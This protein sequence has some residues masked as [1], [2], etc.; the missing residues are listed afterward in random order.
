MSTAATSDPQGYI[1][2]DDRHRCPHNVHKGLGCSVCDPAATQERL[3]LR[4]SA[5]TPKEPPYVRF[6][7]MG[8]GWLVCRKVT[9]D[10]YPQTVTLAGPFTSREGA[11]ERARTIAQSESGEYP[12]MTVN[13]GPDGRYCVQFRRSPGGTLLGR[14]LPSSDGRGRG[15]PTSWEERL[16][17]AD[18]DDHRRII[19]AFLEILGQY[20]L[21]ATT[22]DT[23]GEA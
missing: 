6:G 3:A 19:A 1:E 12:T 10:G 16:P 9:L 18:D 15:T 4:E 14:Y 21:G 23:T 8:R 7:G 13:Y 2:L 17:D 5:S 11:E 22:D 20:A